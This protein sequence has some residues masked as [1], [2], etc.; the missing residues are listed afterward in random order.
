MPKKQLVKIGVS[1][2]LLGLL[3]FWTDVE[4]FRNAVKNAK[5]SYFFYVFIL[6]YLNRILMPVKWN[7]LLNAI[8]IRISWFESVKIY[9]ISSFLGFFLPPTVGADAVRAYQVHKE[10]HPLSDIISSIIIERVLGLIALLLFALGG[11]TVF[12]YTFSEISIDFG[13]LL[14]ILLIASPVLI[15]LF[16]LSLHKEWMRRV[17]NILLRYH[18]VRILG[19]FAK[20]IKTALD[21]YIYYA[22]QKKVLLLFF[23]LTL[24]EVA[25]MILISYLIALAFAIDVSLIYF[26]AFVPIILLFVRLPISF[27]GFGIHEGGFIYFLSFFGVSATLAFSVG[28][29]NHLFALI[30]LLP[31][32]V[33]YAMSG[34]GT[35]QYD[36]IPPAW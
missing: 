3:F 1:V 29:I 2:F 6:V 28:L 5:F 7:F 23:L 16:I 22:D 19:M 15:G 10:K 32:A 11:C 36:S 27:D 34:S 8:N 12:I 17:G 35:R 21:S 25:M 30:G 33:F 18:K 31:G 9:F 13:I 24:V 20:I 4:Q 26:F 14:G